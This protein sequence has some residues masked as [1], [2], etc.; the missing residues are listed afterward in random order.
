MPFRYK[1]IIYF[2]NQKCQLGHSLLYLWIS[3]YSQQA[4]CFVTVSKIFPFSLTWSLKLIKIF[5]FLTVWIT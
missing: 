1:S 2:I 4:I 5:F 3:V